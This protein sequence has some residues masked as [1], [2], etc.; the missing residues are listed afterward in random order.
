MPANTNVEVL[1][2]YILQYITSALATQ[3]S[4]ITEQSVSGHE[5]ADIHVIALLG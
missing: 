1:N 5:F 3:V 2:N 4:F